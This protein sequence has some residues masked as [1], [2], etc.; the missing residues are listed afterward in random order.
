M[1]VTRQMDASRDYGHAL[2]HCGLLCLGEGGWE[3][4]CRYCEES[5]AI[6]ERRGDLQGLRPA[7]TFGAWCDLLQGHAAAARARLAALRD[8]PGLEEREEP[9]VLPFLSLGPSGAGRGGRG[10]EDSGRSAEARGPKPTGWHRWKPSGCRPWW[11][12]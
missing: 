4:A 12:R 6:L 3:A 5:I 11:R 1:A 7:A 9:F 2:F 10:R 8:H